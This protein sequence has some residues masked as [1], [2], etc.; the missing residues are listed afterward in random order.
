MSEK[1]HYKTDDG[2]II[3]VTSEEAFEAGTFWPMPDGSF[4]IRCHRP[5]TK[6]KKNNARLKV[7]QQPAASDSMGFA[8]NQL[9][10]M[11]ANAEAFR[12]EHR[13]IEFVQDP[14]EPRFY[15]VQASSE[16][17]KKRYMKHRKFKDLNSRNGGAVP[18]TPEQL[19]AAK[20]IVL[21]KHGE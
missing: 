19:E 20:A 1:A 3:E 2:E 16:G 7:L 13:G 15:Q 17:A 21:R 11:L 9:P 6:M 5:S 12:D 8:D 14:T 18:F 10:E 4:A